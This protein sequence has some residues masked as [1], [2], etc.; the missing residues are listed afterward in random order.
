MSQ[1]VSK[2]KD[3]IALLQQ[4]DPEGTLKVNID[5]ALIDG[6]KKSD[7]VEYN[8]DAVVQCLSSSEHQKVSDSVYIGIG[9]Q[10][11]SDALENREIVREQIAER[12]EDDRLG[13]SV[14]ESAPVAIAVA[15]SAETY[16]N[17]LEVVKSCNRS[18][19]S[20]D[21]ANSHGPLTV[22]G[23]LAMLAEDAAMTNSRPGSWEGANMQNVLDSHGYGD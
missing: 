10:A 9:E 3:M 16:K 8:Y 14:V 4:C 19:K 2:V 20:N 13:E 18:H 11:T 1:V 15:V 17:L 21:G 6:D 7:G 12:E 5:A 22:S 23:L